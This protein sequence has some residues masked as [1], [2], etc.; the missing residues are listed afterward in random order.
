MVVLSLDAL[1]AC[2]VRYKGEIS[3]VRSSSHKGVN[4]AAKRQLLKN[5]ECEMNSI[6]IIRLKLCKLR[7]HRAIVQGIARSTPS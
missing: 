1:R 6:N 4:Q 5:R 7:G 3:R 2:L